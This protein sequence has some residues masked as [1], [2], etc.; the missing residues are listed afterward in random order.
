MRNRRTRGR[1]RRSRRGGLLFADQLQDV[2]RLGNVG[3]ID[4]GLDFVRFGAAGPRGLARGLGFTG[5]TEVGAHLLRLV[6]FERAGVRF[7]L[8][9]SYFRKYVENRFAFDFQLPGQIVDSNLAHPPLMSSGLFPLKSSLQPHGINV[10]GSAQ[11]R[12]PQCA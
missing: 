10:I 9:D 3:E 4:L 1:S 8:G 2:T 6:L 5:G 7:L 11:P 12:G